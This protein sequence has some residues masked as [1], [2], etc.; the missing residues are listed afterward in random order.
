MLTLLAPGAHARAPRLLLV[1]GDSIS[2]GYG[3]ETGAGW[4]ALLDKR[5]ARRDPPW[6]VVNA[7]ISGDTSAGGLARLPALLRR[8]PD[9]VIIELGGNDALRGLDLDT[10]RA[11]LTTIASRARAS[12]AQVLLLG[13]RVPPNY[14]PDYTERFAAIYPA[15][16]HAARVALLPFFL[17]PVAERR[18]LFQADGIHPGPQAQPMLLDAAWPAIAR[19]LRRAE[20]QPPRAGAA[21][22]A[23]APPSRASAGHLHTGAP[24]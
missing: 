18:D 24:S 11:N 20:R 16:A 23:A 17:A 10:T 19:L 3:L 5:L 6:Q 21:S 9:A 2:A 14:G 12:G 15:A 8:H 13:M 22:R 1:V 4:V 7:S